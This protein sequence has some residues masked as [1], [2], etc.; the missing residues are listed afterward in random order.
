MRVS[1]NTLHSTF[2]SSMSPYIFSRE[3]ILL[4]IDRRKGFELL[5]STW[6][7]QTEKKIQIADLNDDTDWRG[8]GKLSEALRS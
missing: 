1:R 6:V 3:D 8:S 4:V 2:L 5:S 7:P